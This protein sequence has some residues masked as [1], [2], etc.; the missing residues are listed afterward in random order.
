MTTKICTI[1]IISPDSRE[2]NIIVRTDMYEALLA[3]LE[4]AV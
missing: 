1:L 2:K 3:D 4:H